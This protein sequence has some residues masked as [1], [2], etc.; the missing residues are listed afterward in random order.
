MKR[1][2][3]SI[4]DLSES[5]EI[6]ESKPKAIGLI[7]LYVLIAMIITGVFFSFYYKREVTIE[8]RA[9]INYAEVSRTD[10]VLKA[11]IYIPSQ[12]IAN[13]SVND[14]VKIFIENTNQTFNSKIENISPDSINNQ[15]G[16]MF[17]IAESILENKET[18]QDN[19]V[20]KITT[21]EKQNNV[22]I[23]VDSKRYIDY[24]LVLLNFSN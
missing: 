1:S 21:N 4:N 15:E 11:K 6:Y 24:I 17:Y 20:A 13:I 16:Q 3:F 23:I 19:E 10:K 22:S 9:D 14:E 7:F 5:R 12:E 18:S 8:V 2:F